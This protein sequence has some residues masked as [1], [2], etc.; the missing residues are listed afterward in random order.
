VQRVS[1]LLIFLHKNIEKQLQKSAEEDAAVAASARLLSLQDKL[2]GGL[3]KHLYDE[4]LS[5]HDPTSGAAE[6]ELTK[7]NSLAS[8][9]ME[10]LFKRQKA[11]MSEAEAKRKRD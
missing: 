5:K 8:K 1:C 4:K 2:K 7:G 6:E 3:M 10:D 11:Q 9:V